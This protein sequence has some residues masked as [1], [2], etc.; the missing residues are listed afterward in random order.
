MTQVLSDAATVVLLAPIVARMAEPLG[1]APEPLVAS[2]AIGAV[3]AFLTP[4]GHHGNLLV[5]VPGGY[6]FGDFF[7]VGAPLTLLF[8]AITAFV[9]LALWPVR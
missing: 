4:L 2:L 7:R 6:R 1:L 5:Y 3:A 8:A 9:A